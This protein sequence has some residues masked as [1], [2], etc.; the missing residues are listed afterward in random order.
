V[1]ENAPGWDA[2]WVEALDRLELDVD[3]VETM[4]RSGDS[5]AAPM[6]N[7]PWRP[8]AL[9]P[10]PE[11]LR[12]RAV[13]LLDRQLAAAEALTR[14]MIGNRQHAGLL[15]RIEAGDDGGRPAYLD[16]SC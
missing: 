8:P 11:D 6:D 1:S 10:L 15:E 9:L 7:M 13:A 14:A 3:V 12:A 5:T 16:F 2:A 4:L